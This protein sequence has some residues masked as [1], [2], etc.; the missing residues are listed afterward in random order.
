MS[1]FKA[2]GKLL[3]TGEYLVLH[4][5]RA[6]ALPLTKIQQSLAVRPSENMSWKAFDENNQLWLQ[7]DA[8]Q[9]DLVIRVLSFIRQQ[10]PE[11]FK[12]GLSFETHMNFS[13]SW[14]LGSSST[15]ISLLSQWSGLS[16]F[17]LQKHFFHG[18]GYDVAAATLEK[19]FLYQLINEQPRTETV[20]WNPKFKNHLRFVYLGKKQDSRQA[21]AHF[22]AKASKVSPESIQKLD[23]I[24]H[25]LI[26][27]STLEEFQRAMLEHEHIISEHLQM[28]LVKKRLFADFSGEIKSLGGWGGDFILT[29]SQ[30]DP[31]DYFKSKGHGTIFKWSDLIF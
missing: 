22:K 5:A 30:E 12:T 17:T 4:G 1:E 27:A 16:A 13:P 6:L 25:N 9:D 10:R 19:P 28:P 15:F 26:L 24:T 2:F 31:E 14:G 11:L 18:S 29:A 8:S 7:S 3:I 23:Q 21:M 20:E